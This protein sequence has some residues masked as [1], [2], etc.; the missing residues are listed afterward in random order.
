MSCGWSGAQRRRVRPCRMSYHSHDE[1]RTGV[2]NIHMS[3]TR[4]LPRSW[5]GPHASGPRNH[6][7][8]RN[9]RAH[10]NG[11]VP[12][13]MPTVLTPTAPYRQTNVS[14]PIPKVRCQQTNESGPILKVR[15]QQNND[16]A[17]ILKV[18]CQQNNDSG[19]ILKVRCQQNNANGPVSIA[20]CQRTNANGSVPTALFRQPHANGSMA[21]VLCKQSQA[22]GPMP[23]Y[24]RRL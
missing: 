19:P 20:P 16:S 14:G 22:N 3:A 2:R 11:L 6:A 10:D 9:Q 15:Y 24:V 17:P 13:A 18:R 7:R 5:Q 12:G 23:T 8:P 21:I 1:Q 4:G